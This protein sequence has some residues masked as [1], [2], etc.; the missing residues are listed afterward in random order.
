MSDKESAAM[1]QQETKDG[2]SRRNM[3]LGMSAAATMAYAGSTSAAAKEH[4]HSK[5]STQL[6]ELMN[7][8]NDC[9]DKGRCFPSGK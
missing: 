2:I 5:H 4:D 1:K 3:L 6:P 7:A 9:T 8:V